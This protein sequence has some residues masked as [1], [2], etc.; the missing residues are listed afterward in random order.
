MARDIGAIVVTGAGEKAFAAGADIR[1]MAGLGGPDMQRFSEAGRR[2]GDAI[3]GCNKP[4][5]AAINGY[6]LGGG[7]ELAMA[8]DIRIASDRAR[9]GQPEINVGIIAGFGG[10]QRL[11][12]LV[13]AGRAAELL[14]TGDSVDAAT[15]ERI[16]LVDRVV[17]HGKLMEEA[18][19][20]AAKIASKGAMAVALT[21]ACLRAAQEM[22]LASGLSYETAAFGL[23]GATEDKV[24]GMKAFLE[25]RAPAWKGA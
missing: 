6:A 15:A 4:V 17:P 2:L 22:S 20:L 9:L 25:K 3:A 1:E 5:I 21:K 13:G 11:P 23:V 18:M 19:A 8:C 14:L 16:G 24:E 10:T 7:L 12:R